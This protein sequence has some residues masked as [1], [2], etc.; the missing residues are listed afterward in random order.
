MKKSAK[1]VASLL[2]RNVGRLFS[3]AT[4]AFRAVKYKQ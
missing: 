4:K 1:L 3:R 2:R